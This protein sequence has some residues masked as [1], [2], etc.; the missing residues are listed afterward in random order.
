MYSI[1]PGLVSLVFISYGV[2]VLNSR[3]ANRA[4]LT[5]FLICITTFSWQAAWALMFQV[6]NADTALL[7]VHLGYLPILF[8]PTTLYHFIAEL[9]GRRTERPFVQ[10][11]YALAGVL[12]LLVP[13]T[14][15]LLSGL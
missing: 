13:T 10:A 14:D 2:Y 4:S 1:L 7:L 8:L 9:T 6:T 12:A 5:F 11:S 15:W 3:G